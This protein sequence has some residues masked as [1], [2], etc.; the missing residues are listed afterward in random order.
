[1]KARDAGGTPCKRVYAL[2]VEKVEGIAADIQAL[3]TMHRYLNKVLSGWKHRIEDAGPGQKSHLLYSLTEAVK[4]AGDRSNRIRLV[5][6]GLT[7]LPPSSWFPSLPKKDTSDCR[8][9]M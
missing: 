1:L 9:G 8:Q 4:D 6:G 7:L 3:R 5:S 2:A